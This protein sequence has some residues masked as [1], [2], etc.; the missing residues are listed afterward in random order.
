MN[1]SSIVVQCKSDNFDEVKAWCEASEICEY[2]FGDKEKGKII[3]T[4]EGEDVGEEIKKLVKIQEHPLVI[5]ADM[6][7][8]YQEEMLDEEI[9]NLAESPDAPDWLN[10]PNTKAEDIVY[11]GDLK[12]KNLF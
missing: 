5:A 10:D 6:M 3:V 8:T 2:H 12:K 9:R 7:M 4:I 11:H 1:V